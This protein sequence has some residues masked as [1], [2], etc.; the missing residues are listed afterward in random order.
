MKLSHAKPVVVLLF[1][2]G[3]TAF[4]LT[5]HAAAREQKKAFICEPCVVLSDDQLRSVAGGGPCSN[6][7]GDGGPQSTDPDG[8]DSYTNDP[9]DTRNGNLF[10]EFTDLSYLTRGGGRLAL[11]RRYDAQVFSD[12]ANWDHEDR[13]GTWVIQNGVYNG[14]GDRSLSKNTYTDAII[15]LDVQTVAPGAND[16]ETAW[17]NFRFTDKDNRYYLVIHKN[18]LVELLKRVSGISTTLAHNT[19]R[20]FVDP[21]IWNRIR[22][23]NSGTNIK[24]FINGAPFCDVSDST[25]TQGNVA[26]EA[27]FSQCQFDHV[28][29]TDTVTPAN[30][31]SD[32]FDVVDNDYSFGNQWKNTYGD[33]LS[34][35][36][37]GDVVVKRSS[38][39][40]HV[41]VKN[42]SSYDAPVLVYDTLIKNVG[43][44]Y[45]LTTKHG[46]VWAFASDGTLTSITDRNSNVVSLGYN[47]VNATISPFTKAGRS[48]LVDNFD[49]TW[50]NFNSVDRWTDD[51][52]TLSSE[53]LVGGGIQLGW[54]STSDYWYNTM[55]QGSL[56]A[57]LSVY[58]HLTVDLK[59]LVGGEDFKIQLQT[60]GGNAMV[61]LTT[62]AALTTS[63]QTVQIP[64]TDFVGVDL[65]KAKA[66]ALIFNQQ[67][68]GTIQMD[69][70][71]FVANTASNPPVSYTVKRLT[72]IT[73]ASGRVT[74][75]TYGANG[76]VSQVADPAGRVYTF[77]YDADGNLTS[78]TEPRGF[79]RTFEYNA[80]R[81]LKKFI[82]RTGHA[83]QF[84]YAYN[85][86]CLQQ[87]D[88]LG[89]VTTFTYLWSFTEV[90]NDDGDKW[91]YQ[92][93]P[94]TNQLLAI[95]DPLGNVESWVVDPATSKATQTVDKNGN[96]VTKTFDAKG[97][98]LTITDALSHTTTFTHDPVF[99]LMT[100]VTDALSG[101]TTFSRDAKGNLISITNALGKVTPFT[102][103][104]FGNGLTVA[105]PLG[106]TTTATYDTHGNI[107]TRSDPLG[108]ITS[109]TYNGVGEVLTLTDP[110]SNITQY[111]RDAGGLSTS[112]ADPLGNVT[113]YEY[114]GNRQLTK[115]TEPGNLITQYVYNGVGKLTQVIDPLGNQT[116]HVHDTKNFIHLGNT[117]L[118]QAT[119][120]NSH[121]T[122]N[123]YDVLGRLL[124]TTDANGGVTSYAYDAGDRLLTVAD[125][126]G[127]ITSYE[128]DPVD[129][130]KKTIYPDG[131]FHAVAYDGVGNMISG[132]TRKGDEINY[133]YD[134]LNR[135]TSKSYRNTVYTYDDADRLI[136]VTDVLSANPTVYVYDNASRLLNVTDPWGRVVA[137]E[138][139][140]TRNR[141][142]LTYP[143]ATSLTY[144]YDANSRMTQIYDV[145]ANESYT[146]TY[147]VNDRR[148]QLTYPN[149]VTSSY[150]YDNTHRLTS[151][152]NKD[153]VNVV[154]SQFTYTHD[155]VGNRLTRNTSGGL[156]SYTYDSIDRVTSVSYTGGSRVVDY[157]LD[158]V[159]NRISMVEG[160]STVAYSVNNL[161]QYTTVGGVPYTYDTNGSLSSDGTRIFSY[162]VENRLTQVSIGLTVVANEY[163]F[164]DRRIR[165]M[166]GGV[167]THFV[168]DGD[169]VIVDLDGSGNVLRK[170]IYGP[171]I[172]EL[173]ALKTSTATHYLTRD[174]LNSVSEATDSNGNKAESYTYDIYGAA[175]MF[176]GLGNPMIASA[177]NNRYLYIGR[178]WEPQTGLYY[179]RARHYDPLLGRFLQPDPIGYID[180]LNL[181]EYAHSSPGNI[182]DPFGSEGVPPVGPAGSGAGPSGVGPDG[183]PP[184]TTPPDAPS[185]APSTPRGNDTFER[186]PKVEP[187]DPSR[188]TYNERGQT[189]NQD[190]QKQ[191]PKKPTK[192]T[193][194]TKPGAIGRF[195]GGLLRIIRAFPAL[196]IEPMI[197]K[198]DPDPEEPDYI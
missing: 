155:G 167:W 95:T 88:P 50:I 53:S 162:D 89:K 98:T 191:K 118:T 143:D 93:D 129:Q 138:Y 61:S 20:G 22:I 84:T 91:T 45:T 132:T 146:F 62:Y 54:N 25:F 57:D 104:S 10:Y 107:L 37:N 31:T 4:M 44:D 19:G 175:S 137:Y 77:A 8:G 82:A 13:S 64:L 157:T 28:T 188:E 73:D 117:N 16:W 24:V 79:T 51:D 32:N 5:P 66:I 26:L 69:N 197:P 152:V 11:Q 17:I 147:N 85:N 179:Y 141:T 12:L 153:P 159:G 102:Y 164:S 59:G 192:P 14:Q 56:R 165:Q 65:T 72:S 174:G 23:E 154:L 166:V 196:I 136:Q 170:Y 81:T 176:D 7:D 151:L 6:S 106:H 35:Q 115:V 110:R 36:A 41:F 29:V 111:T 187:V 161:N 55:Y 43:G 183:L 193:K 27:Y 68:S 168:Y 185:D 83:Y 58:T 181:Y 130:V 74:T 42:G 119:D 198:I 120:A 156:D 99:N 135:L 182:I 21:L 71:G 186:Q 125:A 169:E 9:V 145:A 39:Q 126:N 86:R 195:F 134:V 34:E 131:T 30:S 15:E 40:R 46:I 178:E 90:R 184:G 87:T 2:A 158:V 150:T 18:G 173:L 123:T 70:L 124:S 96:A 78:S 160:A 122:A 116:L 190:Q 113:S 63:F 128:Y 67:A 108:N 121:G 38:G 163:D 60:D 148:T 139:D 75:F 105:N 80:N 133:G 180:G 140:A 103:D 97:N 194:P 49:D 172:D 76:K 189:P 33:R 47:N 114:D 100:S 3:W 171:N 144:L 1:V 177:I 101:V 109:F 92:T 112:V 48:L 142:K 94:T 127:N 149:G 52:G